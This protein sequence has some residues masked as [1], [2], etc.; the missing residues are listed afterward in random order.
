MNAPITTGQLQL[1]ETVLAASIS[2]WDQRFL[3]QAKF[4]STWSKDPS[5]QVGAV[6]VAPN[7]SIVSVGYNGFPQNMP[8]SPELYA[9]RE[10]K[11]SRIVHGEMN[12]AIWA[13]S[14]LVG[15]TLYTYPFAPCDRCFVHMLQLGIKRFVAPTISVELATRWGPSLDKVRGYAK[16]AGVE[17]VELEFT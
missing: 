9:N 3:E 17:L 7:R 15:C 12:A 11:Y 2:K 1:R 16:E 4:T 14:S 6:I 5:T 13:Q 8:D 10:E